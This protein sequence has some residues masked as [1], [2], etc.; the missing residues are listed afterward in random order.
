MVEGHKAP[1]LPP[2]DEPITL[3][4]LGQDAAGKS[5]LLIS[6][7]RPIMEETVAGELICT[8]TKTPAGV[9]ALIAE[10]S[11]FLTLILRGETK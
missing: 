8:V 5:E 4:A 1:A 7:A 9:A 6:I 2:G 11:S 3:I 10:L